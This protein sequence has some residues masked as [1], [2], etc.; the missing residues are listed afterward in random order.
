QACFQASARSR[1]CLPRRERSLSP[2]ILIHHRRRQ[3][4]CAE[5]ARVKKPR[6]PSLKILGPSFVFSAS[7]CFHRID[8]VS[9]PFG[10][11]RINCLAFRCLRPPACILQPCCRTLPSINHTGQASQMLLPKLGHYKVLSSAP[12]LEFSLAPSVL[13]CAFA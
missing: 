11:L 1:K 10:V 3:G 8:D 5:T 7:S 13:V 4:N 12:K 2:M 9:H 6:V